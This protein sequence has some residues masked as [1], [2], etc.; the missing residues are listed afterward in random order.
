MHSSA[1]EGGRSR[2]S[3][4]AMFQ[5]SVDSK[6]SA[7]RLAWGQLRRRE[8]EYWE[9]GLD[10]GFNEYPFYEWSSIVWLISAFF[11]VSYA[12]CSCSRKR[13]APTGMGRVCLLLIGVSSIFCSIDPFLVLKL[14]DYSSFNPEGL[15]IYD[16]GPVSC[17]GSIFLMAALWL[18]ARLWCSVVTALE[19]KYAKQDNSNGTS[20]I[21]GKLATVLCSYKW[22]A[23]LHCFLSIG[24]FSVAVWEQTGGITAAVFDIAMLLYMIWCFISICCIFTGLAALMM[25]VTNV[26]LRDFAEGSRPVDM[27]GLV[28]SKA[29]SPAPELG[30]L[31][32]VTRIN[33]AEQVLYNVMLLVLGVLYLS[34]EYNKRGMVQCA[35][36][37]IYQLLIWVAH[38]QIIVFFIACDPMDPLY[39]KQVFVALME[40]MSEAVHSDEIWQQP[41]MLVDHPLWEEP[42]PPRKHANF[43]KAV[44]S[45]EVAPSQQQAA[46]E[47]PTTAA[48]TKPAA[49]RSCTA[50]SFWSAPGISSVFKTSVLSA[51]LR[52]YS[53]DG[54]EG[55]GSSSS[56]SG[57][58]PASM[59]GAAS[60]S[61]RSSCSSSAALGRGMTSSRSLTGKGAAQVAPCVDLAPELPPLP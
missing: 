13:A 4:P 42:A 43:A 21:A 9:T 40:E 38:V 28:P 5:D 53:D 23:I 24:L 17:I 44:G 16:P 46:E 30:S 12:F 49:P 51:H 31:R 57:A 7:R 59:I 39:S 25:Y 3:P 29:E 41:D 2:P 35:V 10:C 14:N 47:G 19:K 50:A 52:S 34:E 27:N 1:A 36:K 54:S 20:A 8:C 33:L 56:S 11:F 18:F 58:M 15:W 32:V 22:V 61:T 45:W 60:D 37:V 55:G 6:G 26:S 48:R